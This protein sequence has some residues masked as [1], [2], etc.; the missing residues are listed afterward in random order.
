MDENK[1]AFY[2][3]GKGCPSLCCI[4]DKHSYETYFFNCSSNTQ[5]LGKTR[6][7]FATAIFTSF[8]IPVLWDIFNST[9]IHC[10]FLTAS[11]SFNAHWKSNYFVFYFLLM[12]KLMAT[13]LACCK[14]VKQCSEVRM[15]NF[16]IRPSMAFRTTW[17]TGVGV[18]ETK[19]KSFQ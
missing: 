10:F 5:Q 19:V 14:L 6:D 17:L 4:R 7:K 9:I 3:E 2:N 1:H 18:A 12:V 16:L 8:L 15:I 13:C 11:A